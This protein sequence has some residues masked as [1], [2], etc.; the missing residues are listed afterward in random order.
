[1]TS[2]IR[3]RSRTEY[4]V[5]TYTILVLLLYANFTQNPAFLAGVDAT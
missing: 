5:P 3:S 2:Q 1:M 4:L